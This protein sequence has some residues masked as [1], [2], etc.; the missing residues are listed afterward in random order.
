MV[1]LLSFLLSSLLS[2]KLSLLKFLLPDDS[3]L[4]FLHLFNSRSGFLL[5]FFELGLDFYEDL[6]SLLP[7]LSGC[8]INAL[9]DI[10]K[11]VTELEQSLSNISF[12][13][14]GQESSFVA[15]CDF[16]E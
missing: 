9:E 13:I 1:T 14:E 6:G 7:T 11:L 16:G 15:V 3:S 8:L 10:T 5:L 4:S 2:L 12:L